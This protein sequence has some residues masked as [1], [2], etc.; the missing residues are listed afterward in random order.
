MKE[1]K[2]ALSRRRPLQFGVRSLL[3]IMAAASCLFSF[4][5]VV[6]ESRERARDTPPEPNNLVVGN[7]AYHECEPHYRWSR[8]PQGSDIRGARNWIVWSKECQVPRED[9]Q[10]TVHEVVT[11]ASEVRAE[12]YDDVG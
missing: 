5:R 2:Y 6:F 10:T 7:G 1:A 12:A 8:A 11:G 9:K 3:I 4:A